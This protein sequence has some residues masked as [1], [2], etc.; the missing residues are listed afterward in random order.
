MAVYVPPEL[1]IVMP[2]QLRRDELSD[3]QKQMV[4]TVVK[5]WPKTDINRTIHNGLNR[6]GSPSK[7]PE[8]VSRP[9]L[10]TTIF[11]DTLCRGYLTCRIGRIRSLS[12]SLFDSPPC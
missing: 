11:A 4:A 10:R 7:L 2:N 3:E 8:S 12:A 9:V 5:D 6:I 1:C